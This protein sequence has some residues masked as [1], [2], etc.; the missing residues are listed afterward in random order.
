MDYLTVTVT[1]SSEAVDAISAALMALSASG[2]A[3]DDAADMV[4]Q[5]AAIAAQHQ[6]AG[7]AV[8]GYFAPDADQTAIR[9]A[10]TAKI[11][12]LPDFGLARGAGT[13]TIRGGAEADWAD[14]WKQYYQPL[15]VTRYLTIVP[16]WL[17]YR[18]AQAGEMVIRLDPDMAFGTGKHPTTAMMLQLL[19]ATVRGGERMIDV[20]TGSGVLALAGRLL[21]VDSVLATDVDQVA[22]T[23]AEKNLALNPGVSGITVAANDLL[24][25]ITNQADLIVANILAEVLLPLIPQVPARLAP[26]GTVLLSG[27]FH[28]QLAAVEAALAASGLEVT[29]RL[30]RG[31]WFALSA[32]RPT[33]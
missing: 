22:V 21:G 6:A 8:T 32:A 13:V 12:Q 20:G 28:D 4:G 9:A 31:D 18:P 17:D 2:L 27:I 30:Q 1:T 19:E 29:T 7:A 14:N 5:P 15:R 23:N 24:T 16:D 33:E 11:A 3:I 26:H 25:G 10:L